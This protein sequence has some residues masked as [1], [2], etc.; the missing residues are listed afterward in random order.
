[1]ELIEKRQAELR[2]QHRVP[3]MV[4]KYS[5]PLLVLSQPN[6]SFPEFIENLSGTNHVVA[7]MPP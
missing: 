2:L 7:H 5:L 1:M 6:S 4:G 3:Q